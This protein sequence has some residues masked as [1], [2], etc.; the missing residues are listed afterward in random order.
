MRV[1]LAL[2][3][4][5]SIAIITAC[6]SIQAEN[7]PKISTINGNVQANRYLAPDNAFSVDVPLFLADPRQNIQAY[8][9]EGQNHR[10]VV[11]FGPDVQNSSIITVQLD[12][13]DHYTIYNERLGEY[14]LFRNIIKGKIQDDLA[15]QYL[16]KLLSAYTDTLSFSMDKVFSEHKVF[17]ENDMLFQVYEQR[18]SWAS[19]APG[20]A[21]PIRYHLFYLTWVRDKGVI[22]WMQLPAEEDISTQLQ[23]IK[24]GNYPLQQA[25]MSSLKIN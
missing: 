25:F 9:R 24:T 12:H 1:I 7:F 5:L 14:M 18:Y 16:Q 6:S 3:L 20:Q 23:Q 22:V 4:V 11:N 21:A 10:M 2:M 15:L 17:T 8:R 19:K 13:I